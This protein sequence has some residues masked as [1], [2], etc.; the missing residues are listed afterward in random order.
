MRT[1][2]RSTASLFRERPI[3]WVPQL[4]ALVLSF[5]FSGLD[6]LVQASLFPHILQWLTQQHSVLGGATE[7]ASPTQALVNRAELYLMPLNWVIRFLNTFLFTAA[8]LATAGLLRSLAATGQP[9][10]QEATSSVTTSIRRIL[11]YSLS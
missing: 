10:P 5:F 6:R 3:L 8:L 11:V 7:Y 1:L 4:A 2:W 9:S